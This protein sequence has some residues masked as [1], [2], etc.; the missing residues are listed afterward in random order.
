MLYRLKKDSY[1]NIIFMND[2]VSEV[3][4]FAIE[5]GLTIINNIAFE[6][7]DKTFSLK[8]LKFTFIYF[9]LP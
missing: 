8:C 1:P 7:K 5:Y 3:F 6:Y 9:N 4:N 2:Q